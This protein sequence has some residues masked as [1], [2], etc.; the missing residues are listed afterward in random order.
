MSVTVDDSD[1]PFL[2]VPIDNARFISSIDQ[3]FYEYVRPV[4]N[5]I[6]VMDYT[7]A[8]AAKA[9]TEFVRNLKYHLAEG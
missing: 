3:E 2:D 6:E 1:L 7:Q 8:D 5:F 9:G 4:E